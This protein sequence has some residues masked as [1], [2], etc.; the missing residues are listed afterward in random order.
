MRLQNKTN[1]SC[2]FLFPLLY[3][4]ISRLVGIW[5]QTKR[6]T[7]SFEVKALKLFSMM[8]P[9]ESKFGRKH[10]NWVHSEFSFTLPVDLVC[11]QNTF[12]R[13][14]EMMKEVSCRWK[15]YFISISG[16]FKLVKKRFESKRKTFSII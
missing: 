14:F 11:I 5:K 2:L 10:E 16:S 13:S 12:S 6:H 7:I 9:F 3:I 15:I 1:E 8:S 4:I